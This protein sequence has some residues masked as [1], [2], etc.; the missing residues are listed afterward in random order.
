MKNFLLIVLFAIGTIGLNAQ[1]VF[2]ILSPEGPAGS[3]D[4]TYVDPPT[5]GVDSLEL[6]ESSI[7]GEL[8]IARD[9]TEA[10]TMVC[11]PVINGDEIAGKIAVIWRRSCEFGTKALHCQEAGAIGVVIMNETGDRA[12]PPVGMGAG[13]DGLAVTIPVVMLST[14]DGIA[15]R[16]AILEGGVMVF[17]GN[18]VGLFGDDIGITPDNVLRAEQYSTPRALAENATEFSVKVGAGIINYGTNAQSDVTLN[19]SIT[20]NGN[21]LYNETTETPVNM[22]SGDTTFFEL[23]DF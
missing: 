23:P 17:I 18:K 10:D 8:V 9:G 22:D 3:Y 4:L 21:E 11:E 6:P 13:D 5:W 20:L 19:A 7:T 15:L 14:A 1:V 16:P 2:N 12:G